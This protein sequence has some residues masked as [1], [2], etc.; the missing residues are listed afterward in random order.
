[1]AKEFEIRREVELPATREQVWAAITSGT[2]GWLWPMEYEP[3]VGGRAEGSG[4]VTAWEPPTHFAVRAEGENGWYNN[5]ES[6][7]EAREGGGAMLRWVHSGIFVDDWDTQYDGADKH[8]DFYLHTLG[9][10]LR[11]FAGLTA[12]YVAA[13]GPAASTDPGAF[14]VLRRRLRLSGAAAA[15][16]AVRLEVP[17][18]EPRDGVVDYVTPQFIGIRTADGLYRFFGR[19]AWGMPVGMTLHLFAGDVD[20]EATERAW[21]AWLDGT[22]APEPGSVTSGRTA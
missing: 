19:N 13:D 1:M 2:G 16:D 21:Q 20:R 22:Y 12:A 5:L 18:L 9:Q 15:G 6:V 4:T 14:E 17:G 8:T 11:H 10:Y 7:I 3:R